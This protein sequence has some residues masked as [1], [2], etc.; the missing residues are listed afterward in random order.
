MLAG[1]VVSLSLNVA[2]VG[3]GSA[4]RPKSPVVHNLLVQR[5]EILSAIQDNDAHLRSLLQLA[6]QSKLLAVQARQAGNGAEAATAAQALENAEQGIILVQQKLTRERASLRQVN[7]ALDQAREWPPALVAVHPAAI[8]MRMTG[9]VKIT[10]AQGHAVALQS[11]GFKLQPG[12][13][14]DLPGRHSSMRLQLPSGARIDLG[15]HTRLRYE[16]GKSGSVYD[17]L[18]GELHLNE[19]A[20]AYIYKKFGAR[21]RVRTPQV[22]VAVRG[23]EFI[24]DTNSRRSTFTVLSGEIALRVK[25]RKAAI[26][27]RSMQRL[28]IPAHGTIPLPAAISGSHVQVWWQQ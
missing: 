12:M 9:T 5:E 8:P 28:R 7:S 14:I 19:R 1:I 22:A 26:I 2:F 16:A 21:F 24:I 25:G 4:P 15:P 17:L 27:L 11:Q 20:K 6:E 13:S 18:Q 10:D 23:T 3:H